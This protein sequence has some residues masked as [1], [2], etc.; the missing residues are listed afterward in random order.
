MEEHILTIMTFFPIVGVLAILFLPKQHYSIRWVALVASIIPLAAAIF[1]LIAFNRDVPGM[2]FVVQTQWIRSLNAQFYLGIDGLSLPLIFLT[3]LLSFLGIIASW[4]V[5]DGIK[6]YFSLFLLLEVGLLG[7]FVSLDFFLFFL[8]LQALLIPT[9]FLIGIWGGEQRVY[10]SIKYILFALVG[11]LFILIPMIAFYLYSTPHSFD[12]VSLGQRG[13][14]WSYEN[15]F[16]RGLSF[17]TV[18]QLLFFSLFV[19]FGII[20]PIFPLHSWLRWAHVE[21]PSP[22]SAILAGVLM[23]VG[24]YGLL[25]ISFPILR[26]EANQF[27]FLIALL[28][29]VSILYGA[30]CAL[31]QIVVPENK[32]G[33]DL[34]KLIAFSS[35]SHMGFVLLGIASLTANSIRGAVVHMFNRGLT[36][37]MLFLLVGM[38]FNRAGHQKIDGFGGLGRKVPIFTGF[39]A[40]AFL[41]SFG[42]PGLNN[43]IS[44]Y[45]IFLGSFP[46]YRALTLLALVGGILLAVYFVWSFQKI[47]FGPLNEKCANIDDLNMREICVLFPLAVLVIFLGLYPQPILDLVQETVNQLIILVKV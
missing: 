3:T 20:I 2:Q 26:I 22:V 35:I 44:E 17:G 41:A 45:F 12:L 40:L 9:Y 25:R 28:G 7:V 27:A 11:S 31:A 33:N 5:S 23:N 29:V 14:T 15:I 1:L 13:L 4:K 21:A 38:L 6:G 37:G 42:L 43:F 16:A 39:V 10:A 30:F 24:C 34:K 32:G 18:R 19:G 8:F 46:I 36:A 47:F